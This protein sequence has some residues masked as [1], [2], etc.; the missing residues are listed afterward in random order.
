MIQQPQAQ[1]KQA[2]IAAVLTVDLSRPILLMRHITQVEDPQIGEA[3]G[4]HQAHHARRVAHMALGQLKPAAFLVGEEG[5]DMEP[6]P[7]AN[8]GGNGH[9]NGKDMEAE[10]QR[11]LQQRKNKKDDE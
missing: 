9:A 2:Q 5:F 10:L 8:G 1:L 4:Q 3:R 7:K 11:F 6:A